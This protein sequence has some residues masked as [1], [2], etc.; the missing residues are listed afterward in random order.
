M[1]SFDRFI[2]TGQ[3]YLPIST[4]SVNLERDLVYLQISVGAK[5]V[6]RMRLAIRLVLTFVASVDQLSHL[7]SGSRY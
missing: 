4:L 5:T 2:L 1:W 7:D 6:N 3:A